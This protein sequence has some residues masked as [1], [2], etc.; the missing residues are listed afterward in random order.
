MKTLISPAT[1]RRARSGRASVRAAFSLVEMFVVIGVVAVLVA[2]L[3]PVVG[4]ARA[5]AKTAACASQLHQ[6]YLA[7]QSW[8]QEQV[9]ATNAAPALPTVG[10]RSAFRPYLKVS[11]AYICPEDATIG[12]DDAAAGTEPS[13]NAGG[14]TPPANPSTP[15]PPAG[16]VSTG[17]FV[18]GVTLT[19]HGVEVPFGPGPRGKVLDQEM[20]NTAWAKQ[21]GPKYGCTFAFD[22]GNGD[23]GAL[24]INVTECANGFVLFDFREVK[25]LVGLGAHL[26]NDSPGQLVMM[27]GHLE[28]IKQADPPPADPTGGAGGGGA[29]TPPAGTVGFPGESSYAISAAADKVFGDAGKVFALDYRISVADV[30]D[31]WS[32]KPFAA[33][34]NGRLLFA[35]HNGAQANVL[36]GDGSVQ[37]TD[38]PKA[39]LDP[40]NAENVRRWWLP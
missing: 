9:T 31:N 10:W 12:S 23:F 32:A 4:R 3:I 5:Q 15:P 16:P 18:E 26:T 17:G 35:R 39:A 6:I 14:T 40:A 34:A 29:V 20:N 11:A 13:S 28:P 24:V 22:G 25:V 21:F 36:R 2:V 30:V 38:A 1:E 19:L 37:L 27:R 7:A 33:S 8:R